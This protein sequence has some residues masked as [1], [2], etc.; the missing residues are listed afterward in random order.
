GEQ[1]PELPRLEARDDPIV[2]D[3]AQ[4]AQKLHP[5]RRIHPRS[6]MTAWHAM[7]SAP[8]GVSDFSF[9]ELSA[10]NARKEER[11]G[12]RPS[13]AAPLRR[14]NCLR[15]EGLCML[16]PGRR[17]GRISL[18]AEVAGSRLAA[19]GRFPSP[20]GPTCRR[21]A[22]TDRTAP[23]LWPEEAVRV[24]ENHGRTEEPQVQASMS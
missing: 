3:R 12:E 7:M 14:R 15:E 16:P 21:R 20:P 4:P 24:A 1:E 2:A 18:A 22:G 9:A 10:P 23:E 17:P 5:P 8:G 19:N 6:W 11:R 13:A